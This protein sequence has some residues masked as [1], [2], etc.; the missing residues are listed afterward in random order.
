MV[1]SALGICGLRGWAQEAPCVVGASSKNLR[2]AVGDRANTGSFDFVRLSPH[3]AQDD[4]IFKALDSRNV[5]GYI[6][7]TIARGHS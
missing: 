1:R 2:G 6:T 5:D 4:N 3:F 7:S